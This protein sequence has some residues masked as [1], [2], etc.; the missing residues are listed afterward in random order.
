M[1]EKQK[2]DVRGCIILLHRYC[3]TC[4][5]NGSASRPSPQS[6]LYSNC[7]RIEGEEQ[8]PMEA[9]EFGIFRDGGDSFLELAP[10]P[11]KI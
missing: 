4:V 1:I 2:V 3:D 6:R 9:K 11:H 8:N 7:R 5:Q 10:I